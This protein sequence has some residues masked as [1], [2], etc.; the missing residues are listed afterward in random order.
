MYVMIVMI[1]GT[2]FGHCLLGYLATSK[3]MERVQPDASRMAV[4]LNGHWQVLTE[5]VQTVMRKH[6]RDDAYEVLK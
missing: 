3:G 2:A 4:D 1:V 5:A 6:G